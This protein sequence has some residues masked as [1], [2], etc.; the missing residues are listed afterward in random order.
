MLCDGHYTQQRGGGKCS[1]LATMMA[2]SR[3]EVRYA[4]AQHLAQ[5]TNYMLES[6][7][8]V[9]VGKT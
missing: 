2:E 3:T 4:C 9:T 8:N 7:D 1:N 6:T 5:V